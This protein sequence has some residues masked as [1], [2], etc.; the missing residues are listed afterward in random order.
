MPANQR[1][2]KSKTA[3]A[4]ALSEDTKKESTPLVKIKLEKEATASVSKTVADE[5]NTT[6]LSRLRLALFRPVSAASLAVLRFAFGAVM[7]WEVWRYWTMGRITRYYV[8]PPYHLHF[9]GFHWVHPLPTEFQMYSIFFISG[10]AS[11]GMMLGWWY[12]TSSA[13]TFLTW[14]YFF[15]LEK[16]R[17][18]NHLYLVC[19]L[20]FVFIFVPTHTAYSIDAWKSRAKWSTTTV[21]IWALYSQQFMVGV[22]YFFGGVAKLNKDWLLQAEPMRMWLQK[23]RYEW[24]GLGFKNS[25]AWPYFFSWAGMTLDLGI[26][27]AL[28]YKPTRNFAY[29]NALIFHLSNSQLFTIG[30]FPWLMIAATTIYYP[31]DWPL[32][33][34]GGILS[35]MEQTLKPAV[36]GLVRLNMFVESWFGSEF[37]EDSNSKTEPLLKKGKEKASKE[38]TAPAPAAAPADNEDVIDLTDPLTEDWLHPSPTAQARQYRTIFWLIL[39]FSF[40]CFFPLR[41][42]LY[43]GKVSWN[44]EGHDF[45]W[46]MKLRSKRVL[47]F[48]YRAVNSQTGEETD[49]YPKEHGWATHL[50]MKKLPTRPDLILEMAQTIGKE[51]E[52]RSGVYYEMYADSWVALNAR[53]AQ[54]LIDH[55]KDLMKERNT[56]LPKRWVL[57][58]TVQYGDPEPEIPGLNTDDDG[59]R[60]K[61]RKQK[62]KSFS[63]DADYDEVAT[64]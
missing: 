28:L 23:D 53:P 4:A 52:E 48:R 8:V 42:Y 24:M 31:P 40:H 12:R 6:L 43:P 13:V 1:A 60:K 30:I 46:H 47:F 2:R 49:V 17:Y 21:P 5:S 33:A 63:D 56:W 41:H 20:A 55:T 59:S 32:T 16:T 58:L 7:L 61:G 19:W 54:R 27:F 44:E 10:V 26:V 9:F 11:T 37:D 39:L 14:T 18:L 51:L 38:P 64:S 29:A 62:E 22:P 15:L 57:P 34:A 45:S 35:W 3:A 25:S 50:Q 36:T